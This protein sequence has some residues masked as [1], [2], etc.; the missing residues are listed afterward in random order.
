MPNTYRSRIVAFHGGWMSGRGSLE[1]L[2]VSGETFSI[3]CENAPAVRALHAF[4]GNIIGP[5]HT[6][7]IPA[8]VREREVVISVDDLGILLGFTTYED[9]ES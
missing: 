3:Y 1:V 8:Q 2:L 5:N 4:F 9:W 6:A 7:T